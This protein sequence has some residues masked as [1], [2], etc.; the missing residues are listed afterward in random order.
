MARQVL[1]PTNLPPAP[2]PPAPPPAAAAPAITT[3]RTPQAILAPPSPGSI[4]CDAT[5]PDTIVVAFPGTVDQTSLVTA[6]D[7]T[8]YTVSLLTGPGSPPPPSPPPL[9]S[10]IASVQLDPNN[11]V[12]IIALKQNA[13]TPLTLTVGQWIQVEVDQVKLK[14]QTN[15]L[16]SPFNTAVTQV[17]DAGDAAGST[18]QS[19]EDIAEFSV[20]TEEI[21]YPPSPLA[22]PS[23]WGG[24]MAPTAGGSLGQTAMSAIGAVLGLK[25]QPGRMVDPKGF[26]GALNA[27]FSLKE[28]EGH[29]EAIWT[30]RTYAVQTDLSGGITGA[31]ASVYQRAKDAL[32]KSL[33]L[34]DGLY[35]LFKEAK[36]EDVAALRATVRSQPGRGGATISTTQPHTH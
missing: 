6:N 33:P 11:T 36:D 9:N 20:L 35:P 17:H 7:V 5:A 25:V 22:R 2:L 15:P 4:S 8:K 14:N 26:V 13:S 21:G 28:I 12:A 23:G 19:V 16:G 31:Q 27:S 18:S 1:P 32:D 3:A 30:P 29:T 34:L 10:N 24:A